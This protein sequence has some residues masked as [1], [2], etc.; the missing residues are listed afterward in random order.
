MAVDGYLN[1]DTKI[2][3]KGFVSGIKNI[4]KLAADGALSISAALE[5][6]V[7]SFSKVTAAYQT[8]IEAEARFETTIRNSASAT[9]EQIQSVKELASTLQALGVVGDE[10]QLAGAQELATYVSSVESVKQ[11]LPVLDD[12]IAQQYGFSAST[13][14]AVTIATMLGKV[15]QGQTSAL[16]RYGYSFD[17]AQENMLKYGTE[18]QRVATLAAVVEESVAGVNEAL[19]NTPTGKVKQLSNDFGD[20][21]ETAGKLLTDV[22]Y[23]LV[24]KLDVVVKKLNEVF[25]AAS[26]GIKALLGLSDDFS[27]GSETDEIGESSE[28]TAENFTN[29]ADEA[30]RAEKANRKNLAIFDRFCQGFLLL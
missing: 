15:L 16:S 29:I 14:S 9:G 4:G 26:T 27:L 6:V 30:E 1:F 25:T 28:E 2:N 12:M 17:E 20:L 5:K 10:V 24:V 8:Q 11:M 7:S 19:A 22:A 13:D 3:T 23:P 21:K 18:Q